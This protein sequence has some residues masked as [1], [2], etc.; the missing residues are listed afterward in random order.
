MLKEAVLKE[1]V[2]SSRLTGKSNLRLCNEFPSHV[3]TKPAPTHMT[4]Q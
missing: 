4:M 3:H 1:T 2:T